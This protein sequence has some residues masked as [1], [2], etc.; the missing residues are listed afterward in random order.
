MDDPHGASE[1]LNAH[2]QTEQGTGSWLSCYEISRR[3]F[4][5][6]REIGLNF[7]ASLFCWISLDGRSFTLLAITVMCESGTDVLE[8]N[9]AMVRREQHLVLECNF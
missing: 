1:A 9:V 5:L 2:P 3:M 6:E 7:P 4:D 8:T